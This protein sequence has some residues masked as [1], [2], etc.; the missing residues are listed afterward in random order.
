MS[1]GQTAIAGHAPWQQYLCEACGHVY[2]EALG[3]PDA[4]LP[5][6]TRFADIPEDW[7]CPLC[8]VTKADFRLIEAVT[9]AAS[10]AA[11]RV[12]SGRRRRPGVVIVGAGHAAWTLVEA[13]RAQD[14]QVP[15]TL[16]SACTGDRYDKPLLSVA[17]ARGLRPAQLV[18]ERGVDAAARLRVQLLPHTHAIGIDAQARR[19]RT[20]RGTLPYTR[21]ALAHGAEP[22]LPEALPPALCWRVNHLQDYQRLHAALDGETREVLIVGAG[23][24]GCELANDLALQGHRITLLDARA[25]LLGPW[26][27]SGAGARLL[28]AWQGLPIRFVGGVKVQRLERLPGAP[29]AARVRLHADDGACF[30]ADQVVAATGLRTPSR[31]ARSAGLALSEGIEVSPQTMRSSREHIY[32]LGDCA[33]VGGTAQRFIEPIARQAATAAAAILGRPQQPYAPRPVTVR[34]KTSACPMTLP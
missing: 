19:L 14:A 25:E 7:V 30:D 33:S 27:E 16:V 20:T 18:K 1:A 28:Q 31:L 13:L 3:D 4:G 10:P 8:G 24:V 15:I 12:P 11:R 23:L 29:G 9:P 21:L 34:L 22:A 32:A 17:G 26:A 6:G 2:D 5:P